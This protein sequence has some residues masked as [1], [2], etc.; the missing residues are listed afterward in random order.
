[1]QKKKLDIDAVLEQADKKGDKKTF[2]GADKKAEQ[3]VRAQ[4]G[5]KAIGRPMKKE[6]E[7]AKPF[8]LYYTPQERK[9]LEEAFAKV[10]NEKT[11]Q[12]WSNAIL[13]KMAAVINEGG[14]NKY[15][16]LGMLEEKKALK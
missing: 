8:T 2:H 7:K 15:I 5:V 14:A 1:M 3:L 6:T 12:K 16:L 4:N 11:V 13:L 10:A 9:E